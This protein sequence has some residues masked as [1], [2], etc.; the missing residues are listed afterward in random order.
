MP[1]GDLFSGGHYF[2]ALFHWRLY[3]AGI[4]FDGGFGGKALK[5]IAT[6]RLEGAYD[7]RRKEPNHQS[8]VIWRWIHKNKSDAG[9]IQ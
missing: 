2:F 9:S 1:I 4:F 3:F 5:E 8:A 6:S 7:K